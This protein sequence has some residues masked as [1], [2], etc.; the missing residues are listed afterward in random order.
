[1]IYFGFLLLLFILSDT[2]NSEN[3]PR[4]GLLRRSLLPLAIYY[5]TTLGIPLA[6]LVLRGGHASSD[7]LQHSIFVVI[8][9]II[10]LLPLAIVDLLRN[11]RVACGFGQ[12]G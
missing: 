1:M 7:L 3:R 11:R 6:N 10:L 5:A 9:P 4:V 8:T 2:L 12:L